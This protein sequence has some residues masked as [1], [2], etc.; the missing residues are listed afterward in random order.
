[1]KRIKCACKPAISHPFN[2][3][4]LWFSFTSGLRNQTQ[5]VIAASSSPS[6][7]WQMEPFCLWIYWTY[8][9]GKKPN[10]MHLRRRRKIP[11]GLPLYPNQ[12]N[13]PFAWCVTLAMNRFIW[14]NCHCCVVS[15]NLISSCRCSRPH[16]SSPARIAGSSLV[17]ADAFWLLLQHLLP[18]KGKSIGYRILGNC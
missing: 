2:P 14:S 8:P 6:R 3:N 4:L 5:R 10:P 15:A 17:A 9:P 18:Q 16:W 7:T 11:D 13:V 12:A 1:M